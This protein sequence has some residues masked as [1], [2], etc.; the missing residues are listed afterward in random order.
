MIK[1][2]TAIALV[3]VIACSIQPL[4]RDAAQQPKRDTPIG[5]I[6]RRHALQRSLEQCKANSLSDQQCSKS[7]ASDQQHLESVN[8]R[9]EILLEDPKTNMC[10]LV[11]FAG[12]CNNPI[13]TLGDL[14]DCLQVTADR[15]EA[16]NSGRFV[17]KLDS[18]GCP[19]DAKGR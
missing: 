9:I 11:R 2:L 10:D 8:V 5:T 12:S 18:H 1:L 17:L 4:K 15:G 3:T 16:L 6:L 19:T 7:L 13:Y 14:A